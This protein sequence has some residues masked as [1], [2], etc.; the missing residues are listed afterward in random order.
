[1]NYPYNCTNINKNKNT[2]KNFND[3]INKE[4]KWNKKVITKAQKLKEKIELDILIEESQRSV[5]MC[6]KWE[7]KELNEF[8]AKVW[9]NKSSL[10]IIAQDIITELWEERKEILCMD[11]DN[12]EENKSMR[13]IKEGMEMA[14]ELD[15]RH[16]K[17]KEQIQISACVYHNR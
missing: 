2:M 13:L 8:C 15:E 4:I 11:L 16:K 14:L 9:L 1:M 5:D 12:K 7:N 17:L 10:G 3:K 6:N